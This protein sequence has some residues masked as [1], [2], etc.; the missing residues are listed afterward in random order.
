VTGDR[1]DNDQGG[2]RL[3]AARAVQ[4]LWDG[5]AGFAG[6]VLGALLTPAE[7]GYRAVMRARNAAYDVGVAGSN[8]SPI[9]AI[10]VG[11]ITVGG[12]GKTPVVRWLVKQLIRRGRTP[13]ILHGGYAEDEPAL[14]RLWFPDLPVVA[15]KDRLLG[16]GRAMQQGA[17][18][19]VL[20]D[21]FQHL[22]LKRDLDIVLV[23]T[24]TWTRHARLLPRGPYREP[25]GSL[26]RADM[27][28][29]T[30]RTASAE[31]AARVEV[32]VGRISGRRTARVVLRPAGWI[33]PDGTLR[34]GR[35]RG[36]AIGVAGIGRPDDFFDH[37]EEWG[38]DL[39]D[40]IAFPDHHTY[41]NAEAAEL[42]RL[43]D[44]GPV[45]MTAKD[46]VKLAPLMRN[47]DLWVLELAVKFEG[48][49]SWVLRA[50]EEVLS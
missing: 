42:E 41:T 12:T 5:E 37:A 39:Y 20:D 6:R 15:E 2:D 34:E 38:A 33:R 7:L 8:A 29:I 30:R 1:T 18:V 10:S 47:A 9:P 11:N 21:A 46:A 26:R 35:P 49:R 40:A 31:D 23:A 16:A 17:D 19:L 27:V 43:A 14:H 22:R 44:G 32:D 45:V 48:G 4:R 50:V 3:G 36:P 25:P 28:V 13:G 24:E